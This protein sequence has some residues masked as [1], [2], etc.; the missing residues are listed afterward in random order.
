[1][2][3]GL[4]CLEK[5]EDG[6]KDVEAR[7]LESQQVMEKYKMAKKKY[8]ANQKILGPGFRKEWLS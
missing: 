6:S 8:K 2:R 4:K 7:N 1:M 5:D 3:F